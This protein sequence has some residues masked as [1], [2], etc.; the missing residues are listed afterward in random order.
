M[1]KLAIIIADMFED[2]EYSEPAS[3][4]KKAGHEIIHV[5][6]KAGAT[7]KGL[8]K[9]TEVKIDKDVR[10]VD[11]SMFEALMI[12]GGY[13]PDHLRADENA[14]QFTKKFVE[15]GKPVFIICHGPQLLVTADVLKGRKITGWKSVKQDIINAG[16]EFIDNRVV[17]DGNFVSSRSPA[18]LPDF[19]AA[20]LKRL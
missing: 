9:G 6:L 15:S 16:A 14:V 3:A 11:V 4:F 19:I 8:K 2:A 17:E 13:S 5:G 1:A 12:P 10:D 18:D 20:C 7:V